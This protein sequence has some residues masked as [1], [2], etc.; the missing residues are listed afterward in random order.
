MDRT[1]IPE[2]ISLMYS[3]LT[4]DKAYSINSAGKTGYPED[5]NF[6]PVSYTL[7]KSVQN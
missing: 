6:T 4:C 2:M 1:D 7:Q 3:Q 5:C